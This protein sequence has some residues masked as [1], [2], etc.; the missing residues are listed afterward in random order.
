[1]VSDALVPHQ[2]WVYTRC[3]I[4]GWSLGKI[5]K[6]KDRRSPP[7]FQVGVRNTDKPQ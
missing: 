7:A 5:A 6:W 2:E 4:T 3:L 1:V